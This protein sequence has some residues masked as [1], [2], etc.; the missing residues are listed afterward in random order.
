MESEA[1][2]ERVEW[3]RY[4]CVGTVLHLSG[5][6]ALTTEPHPLLARVVLWEV[7]AGGRVVA[8]GTANGHEAAQAEALAAFLRFADSVAEAAARIRGGEGSSD[9]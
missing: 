5:N 9:A 1:Q 3:E 4:K 8:S 7:A 2:V 6:V